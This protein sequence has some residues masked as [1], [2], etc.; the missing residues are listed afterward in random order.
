MGV[1]VR[2]PKCPGT[3]IAHFAERCLETKTVS[4]PEI[5]LLAKVTLKI[6]RLAFPV[7][8]GESSNGDGLEVILKQYDNKKK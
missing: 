2:K 7:S 1:P 6:K 8:F 3:I 4:P 5:M